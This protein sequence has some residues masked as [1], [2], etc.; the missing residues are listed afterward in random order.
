MVYILLRSQMIANAKCKLMK[1]FIE[2]EL[3]IF[4]QLIYVEN[5][6]RG[7]YNYNHHASRLNTAPFNDVKR[8]KILNDDHFKCN[9]NG[10]L[11]I[12]KLQQI[13][14]VRLLKVNFSIA[15]EI[16]IVN[17]KKKKE[18]HVFVV[19]FLYKIRVTANRKNISIYVDTIRT[20]RTRP[21]PKELYIEDQFSS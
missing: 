16:Y 12:Y 5:P 7:C 19:F 2:Y 4:Y 11:T 18:L 15:V 3:T 17:L 21:Q 8:W 1:L 20:K 13:N 10:S 6:S 9:L 14:A